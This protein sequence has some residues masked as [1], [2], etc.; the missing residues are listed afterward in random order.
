M[1]P[2]AL[3]GSPPTVLLDSLPAVG[4]NVETQIPISPENFEHTDSMKNMLRQED[5]VLDDL[6][7]KRATTAEEHGIL[8]RCRLGL[9]GEVLF[10]PTFLSL[11]ECPEVPNH[12]PVTRR[13]QF[14]LKDEIAEK[15]AEKKK[16]RKKKAGGK[17]A[18]GK[19]K[20]RKPRTAKKTEKAKKVGSTTSST[21]AA[22]GKA[23]HKPNSPLKIAAKG[24][25]K[26]RRVKK[27]S[28]SG[29]VS[30][31]PPALSTVD[32]ALPSSSIEKASSSQGPVLKRLKS[33]TSLPHKAMVKEV[34]AKPGNV[35]KSSKNR[36]KRSKAKSGKEKATKTV[37]TKTER[38]KTMAAEPESIVDDDTYRQYM[39]CIEE[40]LQECYHTDCQHS[41]FTIAGQKAESFQITV[42]WS[43]MAVGVKVCKDR[44]AYQTSSK[45]KRG[46]SEAPKYKSKNFSQIAYFADGGCIFVNYAMA[47]A[48]ALLMQ[49]CHRGLTK[50]IKLGVLDWFSPCV[51]QLFSPCFSQ[52]CFDG[53]LRQWPIQ[54]CDQAACSGSKGDPA[55][56][57]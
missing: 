36:K 3:G 5:R 18:S 1:Q 16:D 12:E 22:E 39:V 14:G 10:M 2:L 6:A 20:N 52:G 55:N 17:K 37:E 53:S 31:T 34:E 25:A 32:E 38:A 29:I 44:L 50:C 26:L 35:R 7:N 15:K 19:K 54:E 24:L 13:L 21:G 42:Y 41:S 47:Q 57:V 28:S 33:K 43:R 23:P 56:H 49:W 30:E 9:S 27:S 48:F 40:I 51:F 4:D 46:K 11:E 8:C 45:T